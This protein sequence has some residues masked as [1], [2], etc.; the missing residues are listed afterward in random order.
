MAR[1]QFLDDV[2]VFNPKTGLWECPNASVQRLLQTIL[3]NQARTVN[4]CMRICE[5]RYH[6]EV[7][8]WYDES[9]ATQRSAAAS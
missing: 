2:A 4:G 9:Q 7:L 6:A 3:N 1:I 5:R 8:E